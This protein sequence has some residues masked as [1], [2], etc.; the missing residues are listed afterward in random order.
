MNSTQWDEDQAMEIEALQSIYAEDFKVLGLAPHQFE[1]TLV[2]NSDGK[3]NHVSIT[4]HV[5]YTPTYPQEV[6]IIEVKPLKGV[7]ESQ[8]TTLKEKLEEEAAQNLEVVMILTLAQSAKEWLESL[9]DK[10]VRELKQEQAAREKA[11]KESKIVKINLD[12]VKP[13]KVVINGTPVTKENFSAWRLKF[14]AE[15]HAKKMR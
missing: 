3:D 4:L 14:E 13:E 5:T 8:C 15:Q 2:P 9:N 10:K 12:D 6:P 1:I 7:G 11:E